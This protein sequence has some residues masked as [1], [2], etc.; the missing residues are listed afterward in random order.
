MTASPTIVWF[1]DDLRVADNPA[2]THAAST[3]GPVIPVYVLDEESAEVRPLGGASKW[4]LHHSLTSLNESLEAL[5]SPLVLRRGSAEQVIANL[6]EETGAGRVVW[7]RRYGKPRFI[8][9]RIKEH[10]TGQGVMVTSFSANA[11]YE[12]WTIN[13]KE[14]KPFQ[15]FTP[16]WKACLASGHP[17]DL[18]DAPASLTNFGNLPSDSLDSWELLPTSP[19]WSGG[20]Q[21]H[22]TPG[23]HGAHDRFDA[24]IESGLEMY[25]RRDEPATPATSR[26]SPHLR[27]GEIS[28]VQIWHRVMNTAGNEKNRDKFLSEVGWREFSIS[29]LYHRPD[30]YENNLKVDFNHFPWTTPDP[31]SLRRWQRGNTGIPLV[32][33]GMRE[34]WHTGYM[35]NRVRM[36]AASFLIKNLL[37]DWRIGEAWF[38]D[39]LVDADEANNPASWQWVAGSGADAA[40]YFR[41][42]NPVTQAERFDE[43]G[44][45]LDQWVPE[46]NTPEYPAPL[47][48]LGESRQAALAAYDTMKAQRQA[49]SPP[50]PTGSNP[51]EPPPPGNFLY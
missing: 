13:N 51:G 14:G 23:E 3:G 38:W 39:T 9:Q 42:F 40:P 8:D 35:H 50:S 16:F 43:N 44:A 4:W 46:R 10:L 34:L 20:L 29:I 12:P 6:V 19:D 36:V 22:W 25:H 28:P 45:Y 31:D 17:R 27:F 33:A 11:L 32:D 2:L 1:R 37:V 26:L 21:D 5:G 18:V 7:S 47:V 15:V 49:G 41:I 48:D 30:V 24:F